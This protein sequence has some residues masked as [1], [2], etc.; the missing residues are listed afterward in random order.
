MKGLFLKDFYLTIYYC[1]TQLF[2]VGIFLCVSVFASNNLFMMVYP[3]MLI[4][5]ISITLLSCDE[6]QKWN[7]FVCTLP[8]SRA[9]IVSSKYIIS[10]IAVAAAFLISLLMQLIKCSVYYSYFHFESNAAI[11]AYSFFL[12]ILTPAL[13][14]PFVFKFGAEKGRILYFAVIIAL[15]S[16]TFILEDKYSDFFS[17]LSGVQPIAIISLTAV[18]V[19]AVSWMISI[20]L[21]KSREF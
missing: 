9:Q 1:R 5:M 8:Y 19:F 13:M 11:I 18:V 12:S 4:G 6:K 7:E 16:C 15:T 14:L 2:I 3:F 17:R 10:I 21:Y 20:K